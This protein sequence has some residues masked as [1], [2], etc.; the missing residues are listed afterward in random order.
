MLG[1]HSVNQSFWLARAS[2]GWSCRCLAL[3]AGVLM[4]GSPIRAG[5]KG[6]T[7]YER[8]DGWLIERQTT[9]DGVHRCRALM[10]SGGAWFSANIHLDRSGLLVVPEGIQSDVDQ[11]AV[12][13][14]R[15]ALQR[16]RSNSFVLEAE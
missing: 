11:E 7:L 6:Y 5:L 12:G 13:R 8:L 3:V 2:L 1:Q 9:V 4:L 10:P 16:C 14:V 15:L